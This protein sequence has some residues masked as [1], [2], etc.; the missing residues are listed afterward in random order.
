MV[1]ATLSDKELIDLC[2]AGN[3]KGY[4]QLDNK[5]ARSVFS[6]IYRLVSDTGEAEDLLQEIFVMVFSNTKRFG[7]PEPAR[8]IVNLFLFEEMSQEE[9]GQT[10]GMSHTAVRSQYHRDSNRLVHMD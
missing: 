6:S 8:T 10:L 5:Y 3:D 1:K 2:L 9:I 4:T 7:L